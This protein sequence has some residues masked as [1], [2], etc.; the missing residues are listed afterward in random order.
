MSIQHRSASFDWEDPLLL[1]QALTGD[2]SMVLAL[3]RFCSGRM[4]DDG[5]AAVEITSIMKRN[6]CGVLKHE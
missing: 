5:T 1:D 4:K 6:S 2:E 3:A